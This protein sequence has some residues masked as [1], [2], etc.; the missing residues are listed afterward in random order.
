VVNRVRVSMSAIP[1]EVFRA[2]IRLNLS[3]DVDH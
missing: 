2:T 1:P 3:I